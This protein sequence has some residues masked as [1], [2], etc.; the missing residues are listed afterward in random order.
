MF[1][2]GFRPDYWSWINRG[3]DLPDEQRRTV[4]EYGGANANVS[5]NP[6]QRYNDKVSDADS[7]EHGNALIECEDSA[8]DHMFSDETSPNAEAQK[9]YDLLMSKYHQPLYPE[10]ERNESALIIAH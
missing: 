9:S 2:W 7:Q 6:L 5:E 10:C 4:F 3:E 8:F 1:R